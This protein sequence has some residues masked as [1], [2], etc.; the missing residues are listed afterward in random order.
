M[1]VA[2]LC[3]A[4]AFGSAV[5]TGDI[6]GTAAYFGVSQEVIILTVTLFVLGFGYWSVDFCSILWD[7]GSAD[8]LY[9]YFLGRCDLC[10]SLRCCTK[11]SDRTCSSFW[12]YRLLCSK[13]NDSCRRHIGGSLGKQ[14]SRN[15]HEF[16]IMASL[17]GYAWAGHGAEHRTTRCRYWSKMREANILSQG[18][19]NHYLKPCIQNE[20]NFNTCSLTHQRQRRLL[21][22]PVLIL[23]DRFFLSGD[24]DRLHSNCLQRSFSQLQA[25][26]QDV[27]L[28]LLWSGRP[29]FALSFCRSTNHS[30]HS[31]N[32]LMLR[33]NNLLNTSW[34]LLD[35]RGAVYRT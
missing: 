6:G 30:I 10:D 26:S 2:M 11:C 23:T 25:V 15:C 27:L 9:W 18:R 3:F 22:V 34:R 35:R 13:S 32:A 29:N 12:R 31:G 7:L 20:K 4:V 5:V 28:R 16:V 8:C 24:I 21:R 14:R 17:P 19:A 1:V 33:R